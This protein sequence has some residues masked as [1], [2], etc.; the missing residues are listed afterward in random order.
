MRTDVVYVE[1]SD[2]GE[3]NLRTPGI[4]VRCSMN[5]VMCREPDRKLSEYDDRWNNPE[6]RGNHDAK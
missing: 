6:N 4:I 3:K 2:L 1:W 5:A